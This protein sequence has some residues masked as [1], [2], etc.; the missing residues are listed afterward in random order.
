MSTLA[1][2]ILVRDKERG[3]RRNLALRQGRVTQSQPKISQPIDIELE[4]EAR[5]SAVCG[6]AP[7]RRTA[8]GY[9][10]AVAPCIRPKLGLPMCP[11]FVDDSV[12]NY[13]KKIQDNPYSKPFVVNC[14]GSCGFLRI[15]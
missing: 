9:A 13:E 8:K 4:G 15:F 10:I 1:E 12:A 6:V 2:L 7:P 11:L 14:F 5:L 3:R